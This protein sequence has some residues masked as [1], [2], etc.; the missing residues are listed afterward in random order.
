MP[1]DRYVMRLSVCHDTPTKQNKSLGAPYVDLFREF[2]HRLLEPNTVLF[3]MGYGFNDE[4]EIG[5]ASCR[6]RV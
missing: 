6:E 4:H 2:Q 5:R 3:V 1:D